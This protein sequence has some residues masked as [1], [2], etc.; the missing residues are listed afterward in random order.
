MSAHYDW[1]ARTEFLNR[2]ADLAR[3]DEWWEGRDRNALA[4]YG[5][6]RVGKSWLLRAFAHGKPARILIADQGA[7]ALQLGRFADSLEPLLGVRPDLPLSLIHISE[8]TRRT[9]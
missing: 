3:L 2:K 8:P 7:P 4:L 1:P 5:R 9:P 6:R